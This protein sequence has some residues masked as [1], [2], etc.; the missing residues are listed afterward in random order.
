MSRPVA[1]QYAMAYTLT[2]N[3]DI[4]LLSGLSQ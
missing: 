1:T 4:C 2:L 3:V